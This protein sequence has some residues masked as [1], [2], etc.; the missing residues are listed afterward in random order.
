MLKRFSWTSAAA[1]AAA[2][3][4]MSS[5]A[6]A[7]SHS[8]AP[9]T[10]SDPD[11]DNADVWAW[12]KGSN[13]V[14]LA[15]YNGLQPAF[16]APNWKK[17]ADEGAIYEIH[18]ARGPDSLD[19]ALTYRIE[20]NTANYPK[21]DPADQAAPVGGGKEFF[22]QISGGGA[23]A[24]TYQ[25]TKVEKNGSKKLVSFGANAGKVAPPNVGPRTNAIAYGIPAAKTYEQFFV[26]DAATSLV[27]SLG[28]GEGRV[29]AGPRDDPFFVDLGAVF[30]LAGLRTV[31]GGTPRNSTNYTNVMQIALEI[32]L[33][34]A[35]GGTAPPNNPSAASTVGVW[36][37][38]SR[39]QI[40][41]LHNN[42]K[43]EAIGPYRQ[44]SRLGLPLINEAVIGLQDK[45]KWNARRPKDDLG[46]FAAYFL[47]P[48]VVRDAEFAGF[49]A[50]GGPLYGCITAGGGGFTLDQLK[51]NR[52]DIIDVINIKDFPTAGAHDGANKINSIG[53]VL[54]VDLGVQ[55]SDFPNG[56]RLNENAPTEPD[57]VDIE[58]GLLLCRLQAL[59]P[60][61]VAQAETNNKATFPYQATPWESFAGNTYGA[62]VQ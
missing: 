3:T 61:G 54:R 57:V 32:P 40:S 23:F 50:Q 37:S 15:T 43:M 44:V 2:V 49:Y 12:V 56:R 47:N 62:P 11:T 25:V 24:Q 51:Y 30:D 9:G 48:V 35:N 10:A 8:E 4:C 1:V 6:F 38:A 29:F 59:V 58:L 5:V 31:I 22:A 42:G 19:D 18:I 33:T 14:V 41:I 13:L 39:R 17:F 46:M 21:V 16:A 55:N 28:A 45:D 26:E 20:F 7:S 34:V 27:K 53:D 36:A 60:D 52:T